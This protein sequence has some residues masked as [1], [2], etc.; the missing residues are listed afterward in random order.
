ML[1]HEW[2]DHGD[3]GHRFVRPTMRRE[4]E[5]ETVQATAAR[6]IREPSVPA[7]TDDG[8]CLRPMGAR[9]LASRSPAKYGRA[10]ATSMAARWIRLLLGLWVF[11]LGLTLM[12]RADLGLSSWD[13]LHDAIRGLTFLTLGQAVIGISVLIVGASLALGVRPGPGTVANVIL[14]G[15]FV[16]SILRTAFLAGLGSA[17]ILARLIALVAGIGAISLG[18]ALYIGAELGAGPRDSLMMAVSKRLH[19][20]P[21]AARAGIEG[22]VVLVGIALG[23]AAGLGTIVFAVLIGPAINTAFRMFRMETRSPRASVLTR[24]SRAIGMWVQRGELGSSAS[25][26]A[27]RYTGGRI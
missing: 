3:A 26:E 17:H 11:A 9:A 18:T 13:V 24:S 1:N 20:S 10:A 8:G 21:G 7:R 27:S 12:V 16:D 4:M 25:A 2:T 14:V 15:A 22:S 23:G 6:R 19:T 5:M